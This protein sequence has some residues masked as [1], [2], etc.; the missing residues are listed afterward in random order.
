MQSHLVRG[1]RGHAGVD[2]QGKRC[3]LRIG[4]HNR[5]PLARVVLPQALQPPSWVVPLRHRLL[6]SRADQRLT[7]TQKAAQAGVDKAGLG[8][9]STVALGSFYGLV[10]QRMGLVA[11]SAGCIRARYIMVDG[12]ITARPSLVQA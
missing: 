11:G 8:A 3:S 1:Y 6:Q 4:L 5:L 10:H 9:R 12:Y 7:L 2:A